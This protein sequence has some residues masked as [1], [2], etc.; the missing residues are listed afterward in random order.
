[1]SLF[2]NYI[3]DGC[4]TATDTH[5]DKCV[6]SSFAWHGKRSP[7][8]TSHSIYSAGVGRM[9]IENHI[10]PVPKIKD[11]RYHGT[12]CVI[13][14]YVCVGLSLY[15][16]IYS[17]LIRRNWKFSV[18]HWEH[19]CKIII[20]IRV[21]TDIRSTLFEST[22]FGEEPFFIW[23]AREQRCGTDPYRLS[24]NQIKINLD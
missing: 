23:H 3:C 16:G 17:V 18:R 4:H 5:T 10:F 13:C 7:H 2:L 8:R 6:L 9:W 12:I 22:S 21:L 11:S 14:C 19:V 20:C 15:Y 24:A 1:M